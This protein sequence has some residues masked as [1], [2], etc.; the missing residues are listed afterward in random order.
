VD[1]LTQWIGSTALTSRQSYAQWRSAQSLPATSQGDPDSD[2]DADGANN[3]GEFL[4]GTAPLDG[5]SLVR[6][7]ISTQES[8]VTI[9]LQLPANRS[10]QIETS[11]NLQSWTLW[12]IPGNQGLATSGGTVNFTAP[13]SGLTQFFRVRMKEN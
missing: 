6:P 12:N 4:A 2:A 13:R 7:L 9:T 10:A 11:T 8:N 1:L 5:A 3:Y